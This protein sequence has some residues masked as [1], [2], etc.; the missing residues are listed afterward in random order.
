M[1]LRNA[2]RFNFETKKYES[3]KEFIDKLEREREE[4]NAK[5]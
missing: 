2:V 1:N 3:A 5:K 4:K